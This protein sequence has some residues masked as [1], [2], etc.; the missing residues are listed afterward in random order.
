MTGENP[1][2]SIPR[3]LAGIIRRLPSHRSA[4]TESQRPLTQNSV[5]SL[6]GPERSHT[7]TADEMRELFRDDYPWHTNPII[8]ELRDGTDNDTPTGIYNLGVAFYWSGDLL[9]AR[10]CF[11]HAVRLLVE[12]GYAVHRSD[13]TVAELEQVMRLV[14]RIMSEGVL[15]GTE[16]ETFSL[17]VFGL[18]LT[19]TMTED[20]VTSDTGYG[21][22]AEKRSQDHIKYQLVLPTIVTRGFTGEYLFALDELWETVRQYTPHQ[23]LTLVLDADN[24]DHP[25]PLVVC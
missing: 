14:P 19:V 10:D 9:L 20:L 22:M 2:G 5:A 13:S 18:I 24:L 23:R 25:Y 3:L 8:R 17:A 11:A 12:N 16:R 6:F 15:G 21:Q 1:L 4:R 7:Q